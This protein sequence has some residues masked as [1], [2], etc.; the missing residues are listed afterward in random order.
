MKKVQWTDDL[1]VGVGAIDE[2][3]QVWLQHLNSLT[4]SLEAHQGPAKIAS[5]LDFLIE[6]THSHFATEE[7]FMDGSNYPEIET[8]K[9]KHREF[10]EILNDME[11]EFR[12]DGPTPI[13]VESV[14]TL[15]ANWLIKHILEVDMEFGAFLKSNGIAVDAEG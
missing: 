12:D 2:Q 9:A 10:K 4:E 5:M 7:S 15:L 8:H 3:H 6:Y 1:S 13:L 14:N 11:S